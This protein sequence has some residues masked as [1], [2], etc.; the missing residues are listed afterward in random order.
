MLVRIREIKSQLCIFLSQNE[1]KCL[2][3]REVLEPKAVDIHWVFAL[4]KYSIANKTNTVGYHFCIC[5]SIYTRVCDLHPLNTLQIWQIIMVT[6]FHI[7]TLSG[8]WA[9]VCKY[10]LSI[11]CLAFHPKTCFYFLAKRREKDPFF[12]YHLECWKEGNAKLPILTKYG[13]ILHPF[14]K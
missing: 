8:R 2:F 10:I 6:I 5:L 7:H 11:Y 13:Y 12:I 4:G 1:V 9:K 3:K 14:Q